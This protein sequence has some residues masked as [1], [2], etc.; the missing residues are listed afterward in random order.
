MSREPGLS[1]GRQEPLSA[2][3]ARPIV[4]DHPSH[5]AAQRSQPPTASSGLAG[6]SA[7]TFD[8]AD[9]TLELPLDFF[10]LIL[11]PFFIN[12]PFKKQASG[13]QKF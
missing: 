5:P 12:I 1:T 13:A 8:S 7:I 6:T 11:V 4:V 10:F 2:A 9:K 3:A